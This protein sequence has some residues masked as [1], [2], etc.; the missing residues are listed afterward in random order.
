M[1]INGEK[2]N[3]PSLMSRYGV[4]GFPS[5]KFIN[6][7]EQVVHEIGGYEALNA[8]LNDMRKALGQ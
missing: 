3:G 5:I 1:K 2:G 4:S 8:F 7:D 6:K